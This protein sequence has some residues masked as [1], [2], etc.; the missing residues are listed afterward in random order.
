[1]SFARSLIPKPQIPKKQISSLH[2]HRHCLRWVKTS[3]QENLRHHHLSLNCSKYWPSRLHQT[4]RRTQT[5]NTSKKRM[6]L[7]PLPTRNILVQSMEKTQTTIQKRNPSRTKLQ[8]I[9][10]T[11]FTLPTHWNINRF[12]GTFWERIQT[13]ITWK[14]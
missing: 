11:I 10:R 2:L 14:Q 12:R 4:H 3:K 6:L 7:L 1:M 5:T 9:P 13:C 8:Q